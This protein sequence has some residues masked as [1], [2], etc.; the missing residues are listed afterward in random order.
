MEYATPLLMAGLADAEVQVPVGAMVR[1]IALIVA[2]P[3]AAGMLVR[4]RSPAWVQ[5]AEPALPWLAL[6]AVAFM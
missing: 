5:R 6:A 1:S 3:V 4:W 2:L